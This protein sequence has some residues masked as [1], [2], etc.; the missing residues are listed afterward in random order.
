MTD[1]KI[2][3]KPQGKKERQQ[4]H[5]GVQKANDKIIE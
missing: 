4:E 5:F 3:E 1:K 2:T